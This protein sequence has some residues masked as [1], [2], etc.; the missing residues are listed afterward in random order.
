MNKT[1]KAKK[2]KNIQKSNIE[3]YSNS[4]PK[5]QNKNTYTPKTEDKLKKYLIFIL[6]L[7][8]Q[9]DSEIIPEEIITLINENNENDENKINDNNN[10]FNQ[11]KLFISNYKLN[12][13]IYY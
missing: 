11:I 3:N 10:D 9:I 13:I 5:I 12:S 8:F 7:T 6:Y 2:E 4:V 1:D